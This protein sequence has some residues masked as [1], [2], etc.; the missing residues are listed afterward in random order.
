MAVLYPL[1]GLAVHRLQKYCALCFFV[2]VVVMGDVCGLSFLV[3]VQK[4]QDLRETLW[5]SRRVIFLTP[6]VCGMPIL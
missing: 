3:A 2:Y 4:K 6:Q 5:K 1:L